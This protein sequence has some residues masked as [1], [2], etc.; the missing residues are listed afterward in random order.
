MA[1]VETQGALE[2]EFSFGS[3]RAAMA[4][5]NKVAEFAESQNHHPEIFNSYCLVKLRLTTHDEGS[6]VTDKDW[7]LARAIDGLLSTF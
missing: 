6:T 2:A 3:F 5:L 7:E 4:F 1:W